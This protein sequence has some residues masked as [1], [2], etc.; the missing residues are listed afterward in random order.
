MTPRTNQ[1]TIGGHVVLQYPGLAPEVAPQ[2]LAFERSIIELQ[3]QLEHSFT[4]A[5]PIPLSFNRIS[6]RKHR[7][8][9]PA[10]I[11]TRR[12]KLNFDRSFAKSTGKPSVVVFDRGLLDIP[13][14]LP[15]ASWLGAHQCDRSP[16]D[17]SPCGTDTRLA[18]DHSVAGACRYVGQDGLH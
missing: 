6:N 17:G 10:F 16:C 3:M 18:M 13:A 1:Q 7:S 4:C 11:Q 15:R 2:L 12:F 5:L 14:Y 8:K 9:P